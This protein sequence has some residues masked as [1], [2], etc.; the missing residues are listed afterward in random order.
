MLET[1]IGELLAAGEAALREAGVAAARREAGW[2]LA[3]LLGVGRL[4]LDLRSDRTVPEAVRRRFTD[5]LARRQARE[6]LQYIL[7]FEEFH[8]LTLR[9]GPGAL[10]PRPE[11]EL[12]VEWAVELGRGAGSG[13][14]AVDV[15]TGGG[16]VACALARA[17]PHFQVLA[18]E[19]SSGAL[20]LAAANVRALGLGDRV[21]LIQGDLLT[22]LA[23]LAVDL[24]VSN[25]P[26]I[27]SGVLGQLPPEV[28]DWE[29]REALDGGPDG[30]AVHRRL[31]AEAPRVL[32][33]GGWLLLELGEGQAAGARDLLAAGG[34]ERIE[35]RRDLAG[36]ER[37]IAGRRP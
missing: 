26:Y 2:L 28:R 30:M 33:S 35:V 17:L 22:P 9:T 10:I 23:R 5:R 34:F 27:P 29:P 32:G 7:G 4:T 19:R 8:G 37:M 20:A 21:R 11:T 13:R 12:L 18:L 31:A 24:V 15:G 3:D 1:T 14:R 25:P 16:A 36:T 6:P